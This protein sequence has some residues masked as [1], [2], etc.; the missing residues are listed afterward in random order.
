MSLLEVSHLTKA[1]NGTVAVS[2]LS[3]TVEAGEIF[4]L[5]GP[6]GAGKSTTMMM[7]AGLR[8]P[9]SGTISLAGH[10]ITP[11]QGRPSTLLGVVP[12]DLAIYPELTARENLDFFGSIYGVRGPA[13]A[14]RIDR[15]LSQ[16]GL[17]ANAGQLV[18][19][20]SGGMK[21][22]LN[23]GV[24]L[25]HDPRFVIL[26][27]PTVGVDPQSRSHLLA[28]IRQL[29]AGGV[30]VIYASHYMEEVEV[31]CQRVAIIDRGKL[32]TMG[33]IDE[34]LDKARSDLYLKVAANPADLRHR[35]V[36]LA[37]VT[38]GD[39]RESQVVVRRERR[40][41]AGALNGRLAAVLEVLAAGGFEL[42]EIET[43]E[44]NLE[45]LFLQLTGR[46][47]RD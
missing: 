20:F 41:P 26:D 22:R 35:L 18:G 29:A 9:D 19:T 42:L 25:M 27:E 10:L 43:R 13:L 24:G 40:A 37:D 15:I 31:L 33:A 4:G 14:E 11:G 1:Y 23:F 2:D 32:L 44:H 36:G 17:K 6:N 45:R 16:T 5:L 47:L 12:Q 21:R 39:G 46:R 28:C 30:G 38:A 34:L 7:L 8:V 3:F